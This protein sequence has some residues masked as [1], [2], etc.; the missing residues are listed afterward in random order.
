MLQIFSLL[1]D[2]L[3][4]ESQQF[5]NADDTKGKEAVNKILHSCRMRC[6]KMKDKQDE[7]ID[8]GKGIC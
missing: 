2:L 8:H 3:N 5:V 6:E 4:I 7:D 1:V